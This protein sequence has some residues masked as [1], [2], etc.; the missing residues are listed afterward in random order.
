[1]TPRGAAAE[2]WLGDPSSSGRIL[3]T[4]H[5]D[6]TTPAASSLRVVLD[7]LRRRHGWSA[8]GS[9]EDADT[10]GAVLAGRP[11]LVARVDRAPVHVVR[12]DRALVLSAH[13][14]H[15]DGLG[16]LALLGALAGGAVTSDA[17]GVGD[18][19]PGRS[20]LVSGVGRS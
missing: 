1:M 11:Q 8:P 12:L 3:L 13:H 10:P 6:G 17:R 16:L 5:L 19:P 7:D 14:A 2:D 15:V 4:A 18:R 9:V 20:A